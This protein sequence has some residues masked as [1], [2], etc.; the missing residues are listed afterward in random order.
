MA[1][2]SPGWLGVFSQDHSVDKEKNQEEYSEYFNL[3]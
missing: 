1:C 3:H 2:R